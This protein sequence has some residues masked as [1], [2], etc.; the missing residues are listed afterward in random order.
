MTVSPSSATAGRTAKTRRRPRTSRA[1]IRSS[2][3]PQRRG[4]GSSMPPGTLAAPASTAARTRWRCRPA[5]LT[6]RPWAA[7]R[8]IT[9]PAATHHSEEWWNGATDAPPTG[10]GGFGLSA[11]FPRPAYQDGFHAPRCGRSR[12]SSSTPTRPRRR[13][14]SGLGRRLPGAA[15]LRR[16]QRRGAWRGRR[17][18]RSSTKRSA[19]IS[20]TR[21]RPF[22][23]SPRATSS[24]PPQNW[25]ATSH[26]SASDPQAQC[27]AARHPRSNARPSER[28]VNP[29]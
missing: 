16:H 5:R 17:Q 8:C 19:R 21:T 12:T 18:R 26:M 28:A 10:Q 15:L 9:G 13:D 25:A 24:T 2:P 3:L 7:R 22:M 6:P 20:A 4:S 29:R 23:P 1:S 27:A 11:F 14:L